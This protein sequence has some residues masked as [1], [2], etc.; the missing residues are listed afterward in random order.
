MFSG[1]YSKSCFS[2]F[3]CLTC[4]CPEYQCS[5]AASALLGNEFAAA[6]DEV[7]RNLSVRFLRL[8]FLWD[9]RGAR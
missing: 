7:E 5:C 3:T 1:G 9:N 4:A 2:A 8:L 6:F